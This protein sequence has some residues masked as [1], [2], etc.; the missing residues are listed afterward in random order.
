M[1]RPRRRWRRRQM[2][3]AWAGGAM[4]SAPLLTCRI[5][6]L[7][8]SLL[9][10]GVVVDEQEAV[11]CPADSG[12]LPDTLVQGGQPLEAIVCGSTPAQANTSAAA[13]PVA[14]MHVRERVGEIA[15]VVC[16]SADERDWDAVDSADRLPGQLRDEIERFVLGRRPLDQST[17][18]IA[19]GT[20]ADARETIDDAAARWAATVDGRG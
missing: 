16:V 18:T 7:K 20:P 9:M 8:G 2:R 13:R 3:W 12:Y 6:N 11:V 19:W 5:E 4:M 14:V 15:V 10:T 17:A 1:H